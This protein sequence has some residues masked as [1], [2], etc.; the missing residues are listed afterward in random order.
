MRGNFAVSLQKV[1]QC[2]H[3]SGKDDSLPSCAEECHESNC[4]IAHSIRL[5]DWN[6]GSRVRWY[7]TKSSSGRAERTA[8]AVSRDWDRG[9]EGFRGHIPID[10]SLKRVSRRDAACRW[11]VVQLEY[12]KEE[13]P[14]YAIYGTVL[15][16]IEVQRTIKRWKCG[17]HKTCNA[18]WTRSG[19]MI[20]WCR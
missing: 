10:G 4:L 2:G 7:G 19:K 9:V 18:L 1:E 15:A 17:R 20:V 14:R 13:V 8:R 6:Q 11:A 12:D 16:D 3:E 5:W